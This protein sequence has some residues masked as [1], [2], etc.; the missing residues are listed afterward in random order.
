MDNQKRGYVLSKNQ[1]LQRHFFLKLRKPIHTTNVGNCP[2]NLNLM[3]IQVTCIQPVECLKGTA[4]ATTSINRDYLGKY[5]PV[6]QGIVENHKIQN[7]SQLR[8]KVLALYNSFLSTHR[9]TA[10]RSNGWRIY[11]KHDSQRVGALWVTKL[12]QF[13]L[14]NKF[15]EDRHYY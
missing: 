13:I 6:H 10:L 7:P 8:Q 2:Y 9:K 14:D 12:C 11:G 15:T 5:N 4:M 3:K 1:V